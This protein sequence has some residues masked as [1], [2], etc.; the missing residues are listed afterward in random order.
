MDYA[1]AT[2]YL[3]TLANF[4]RLPSADGLRARRIE[5][6]QELLQALGNPQQQYRIIHVAGTKGKGS[7]CAMVYA[8]LRRQL[9]AGLYTSP[10]VESVRERIRIGDAA[11]EAWIGEAEFADGI[12]RVR[13]VIERTSIA[14]GPV[15]YFE[16]M[17]A[18]AF[19]H[20]ARAGVQWAVLE[21]GLGGRLDATNAGTAEIAGL[22]PISYDHMDVLGSDLAGIATEKAAIIKPQQTVVSAPQPP[23][24]ARVIAARCA[25]QHVPLVHVG[26]D[27]TLTDVRVNRERTRVTVHGQR[28]T[29]PDLAVPLL[30]RHQAENVAMAVACMEAVSARDTAVRCTPELLRDGLAGVA[31]PGRGEL[32]PT[33]PPVLLDGAHNGDS[34]TRLA[35]LIR[36]LFPDTRVTLL[37]GCSAGKDVGAIAQALASVTQATWAVEADHPRALPAATLAAVARPQLP[38]IRIANS[39]AAALDAAYAA[40]APIVVTGSLF[41][42]TE[43]KAHVASL[44]R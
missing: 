4:E 6:M 29:Y 1:E 3:D 5:R 43:A 39:P 18:L 17:T 26:H 2:Q 21:T 10:H 16:A 28:G 12:T 15:T 34:A 31:W 11:R 24:A 22:A 40:G 27:V 9:R 44:A 38:H 37:L 35:E 8:M 30:G 32:L 33:T 20:F 42:I 36:D 7:V 13:E 14:G 41:I 23:A 25:E 19:D